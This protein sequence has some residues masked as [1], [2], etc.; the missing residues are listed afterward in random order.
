MNKKYLKIF[1]GIIVG[2]WG[3]YFLQAMYG[4]R[5][6]SSCSQCKKCDSCPANNRCSC[7]REGFTDKIR[8]AFRDA[9]KKIDT[10]VSDYGPETIA[11]QFKKWRM[12]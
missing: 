4:T 11:H 6:T 9:N 7:G 10:F 12:M 5:G 1:I 8:P 3:I 2:L